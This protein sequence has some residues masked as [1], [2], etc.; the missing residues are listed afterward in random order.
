[1][2]ELILPFLFSPVEYERYEERVADSVYPKPR[3]LVNG[4]PL[5]DSMSFA[6]ANSGAKI[7]IAA[8]NFTNFHELVLKIRA[9][10]V[11]VTR[12]KMPVL[13]PTRTCG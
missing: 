6:L 11:R 5:G 9:R 13:R 4:R 2:P 1:L 8:T 3:A 10:S 12:G 7:K